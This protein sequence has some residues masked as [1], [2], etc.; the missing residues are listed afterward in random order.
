M[1]T[2]EDDDFADLQPKSMLDD[3]AFK[4]LRQECQ[5][6]LLKESYL[7][8]S[9]IY[10]KEISFAD[11]LKNFRNSFHS[12]RYGLTEDNLKA[13]DEYLNPDL[14]PD[15]EEYTSAH[16]SSSGHLANTDVDV[17]SDDDYE[18][19]APT[20]YDDVAN[21]I[22]VY[23]YLFSHYQEYPHY[24]QLR[25]A[26]SALF[27]ALELEIDE[28]LKRE[29]KFID[30][31]IDTS[32]ISEQGASYQVERGK[33]IKEYRIEMAK[34]VL[35]LLDI[36]AEQYYE[37]QLEFGSY[38]DDEIKAQEK[39]NNEMKALLNLSS[40]IDISGKQISIKDMLKAQLGHGIF[41]AALSECN[42]DDLYVTNKN[43]EGKEGYTNKA[44]VPG[45]FFEILAVSPAHE[46]SM[47][48]A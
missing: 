40:H 45:H 34:R 17:E 46:N 7:L 44:Y 41:A 42:Q 9:P 14:N 26:R 43:T 33:K 27:D 22:D 8:F 18:F 11:Y 25:G 2:L 39:T 35:Y 20:E 5:K 21:L 32:L 12:K 6:I 13:K 31:K 15:A 37:S 28:Y 36:I 16:D 4:N 48:R 29:D 3:D 24:L 30:E 47:R 19:K 23:P 10:R 1:S 38:L